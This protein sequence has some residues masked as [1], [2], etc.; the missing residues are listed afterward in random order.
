M[1]I[2][3][4]SIV[5]GVHTVTIRLR[6][7]EDLKA[8]LDEYVKTQNIK[9]AC[10]ITCAGSLQQAAIQ[11]ANQPNTD[12][13]NEKFEIVSLTGTLSLTGS[14]LHIA[15]SDKTGK[16]IGGHLKEGSVVYTTAEIVIAILP[17]VVYER[18][19]DPTYGYK[20]L[21]IEKPGGETLKE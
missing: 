15:V 11:Y 1:Q 16:T 9:A 8:K 10:I 14:H 2:D 12:I 17:D 19:T 5:S 6:P 4:A 7:G 13:I 21:V 3:T 18:E 20:E